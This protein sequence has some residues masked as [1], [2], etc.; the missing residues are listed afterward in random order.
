MLGSE[1]NPPDLSTNVQYEYCVQSKLPR[2]PF[3]QVYHEVELL[4]L[5]H[6][7]L[8]EINGHF[9][10]SGKLYFIMFIDYYSRYC[11]IYLLRTNDEAFSKFHG[12]VSSLSSWCQSS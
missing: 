12:V 6:S 7:D 3:R 2:K 9:S 11:Y 4:N 1:N 8:C 5:V 10:R